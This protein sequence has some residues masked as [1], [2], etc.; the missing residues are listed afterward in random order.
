MLT[1]KVL[2]PS[3]D[4]KSFDCGNPSLNNFLAQYAGQYTKKGLAKTYILADD[5]TP[6]K[7]LG[8]YSLSNLH[9]EPEVFN[10][11][12]KGFPTFIN[13]PCCLIGRLAVDKHH[14]GQGLSRHL[15][16]HALNTIIK[17]STMSGISFAVVDAKSPDLISF[18]E[19]F[20]FKRIHE[21]SLRM[22]L[23]ITKLSSTA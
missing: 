20:G 11:N 22:Y 8:F 21:T 13:I 16:A 4:R 18:Y 9:I 14:K 6:P 23:N 15:L 17:L 7:V 5:S 10:P 2:N 19:R 12:L 1:V 3:H